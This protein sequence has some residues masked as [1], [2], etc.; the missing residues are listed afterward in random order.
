M[1][2]NLENYKKMK[3]QTKEYKEYMTK[4]IYDFEDPREWDKAL[5]N[6]EEVQKC[7]VIL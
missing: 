2:T 6:L 3:S 1:C 4:A 5:K 7:K